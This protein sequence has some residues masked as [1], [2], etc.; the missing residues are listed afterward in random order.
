MPDQG[1]EISVDL[2][3]QDPASVVAEISANT[4]PADIRSRART[5]GR[6]SAVP[7]PRGPGAQGGLSARAGAAAA[8]WLVCP[9][10]GRLW[11]GQAVSAAGDAM[12][13]VSAVLA[14]AALSAGKPWQA[15]AVAGVPAAAYAAIAVAGPAGGVLADRFDRRAVM[16]ATEAA[17]AGVTALLAAVSFVPGVPAAVWLGC[18]YAAVFVLNAAGELF[19]PARTA[20]IAVLIP[21][22]DGRARA[23]GLAESAT[24]ATGIVGTALA[25]PLMAV[26]GLHGALAVDAL[27]YAASWASVRSLPACPG[28]AGRGGLRAELAEGWRVFG[29]SR[30][31]RALLSVTATCQ[32]GTAVLTALN[33]VAVRSDL[34]GGPATFG[35]AEAVM[36]AGYVIGSAAARRLT[37]ACGLRAVNWG[38]LAAAGVTAAAYALARDVPAGLVLLAAYAVAIGVLTAAAAPYLMA[39]ADDEHRG[40]VMSVFRPANQL[41][42]GASVLACGWLAGGPLQGAHV[43]TLGPVRL[44]LLAG[45]LVIIA[46]GARAYAALPAS[47][48]SQT[49]EHRAI[50][51]TSETPRPGQ[52]IVVSDTRQAARRHGSG[53]IDPRVISRRSQLARKTREKR[54]ASRRTPTVRAGH[55]G[56]VSDL[57]ARHGQRVHHLELL[58]RAGTHEGLRPTSVGGAPSHR[59]TSYSPARDSPPT[60][61]PRPFAKIPDSSPSRGPLLWAPK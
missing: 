55:H 38:G 27:T 17:R 37:A 50:T 21:G 14:V 33:A 11:A 35:I 36:G 13:T 16:M 42:A 57:R 20:A 53:S 31:L 43:G 30:P 22:A 61:P 23:A 56:S 34:H 26:A 46:A 44:L 28:H 15:A 2:N 6:G 8:R 18:L 12:L 1:E 51:A 54:P 32:A 25:V 9:A 49:P 52:S 45:S 24:S 58:R 39:A 4:A 29:A 59:T 3:P 60:R 10:Y 5:S 7:V 47:P 48:D 41:V 19:V 40:R